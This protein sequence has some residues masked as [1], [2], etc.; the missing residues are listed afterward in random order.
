MWTILRGTVTRGT[1]SF[2][3]STRVRLPDD[4]RSMRVIHRLPTA[5]SVAIDKTWIDWR[6][7]QWPIYERQDQILNLDGQVPCLL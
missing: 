1:Y 6:R 3:Y 2:V 7:L 4:G 5:K